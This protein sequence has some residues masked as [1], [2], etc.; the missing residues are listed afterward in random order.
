MDDINN[1]WGKLPLSIWGSQ[2]KQVSSVIKY[3]R[4]IFIGTLIRRGSFSF[5]TGKQVHR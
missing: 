5:L 1:S 2:R 3:N 4:T